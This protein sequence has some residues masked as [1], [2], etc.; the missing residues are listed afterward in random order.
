MINEPISRRSF[1]IEMAGGTAL[2]LAGVSLAARAEGPEGVPTPGMLRIS[3]E[4]KAYAALKT[5][6]KGVYVP[7]DL[8]EKPLILWRQ[9]EKS[10]RAFSSACTHAACKVRLPTKGELK[11]PCH[12][13]SFGEDGRPTAGPAKETLREFAARLEN[14]FV[15]IDTRAPI[16]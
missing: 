7:V 1:L 2:A 14:G 4:D 6:G 15:T 9:T 13:S 16:A 10:V 8:Q 3:L 12:G 5:V 11:C